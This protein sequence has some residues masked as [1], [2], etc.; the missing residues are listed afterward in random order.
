MMYTRW[1]GLSAQ[2]THPLAVRGFFRL[3]H[4]TSRFAA[5]FAAGQQGTHGLRRR[6]QRTESFDRPST[7]SIAWTHAA[8][9]AADDHRRGR[10]LP[11][12][13]EGGHNE[14]FEMGSAVSSGISTVRYLRS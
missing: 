5:A 2:D 13:D 6:S 9:R 3:E 10:Q 14:G 8:I 7:I 12:P 4:S 1:L 11:T